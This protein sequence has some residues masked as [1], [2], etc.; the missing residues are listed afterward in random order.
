VNVTVPVGTPSAALAVA[1]KLTDWPT[2]DGFRLEVR[3][4]VVN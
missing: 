1:V 4:I 2:T 3:L